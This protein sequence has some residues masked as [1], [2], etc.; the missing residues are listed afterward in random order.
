M[1]VVQCKGCIILHCRS[2]ASWRRIPIDSG[3][4]RESKDQSVALLIFERF[5]RQEAELGLVIGQVEGDSLIFIDEILPNGMI[6][7]HG[8]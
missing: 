8:Q 2:L 5:V 1:Y 3:G 4:N 6:E 7:M